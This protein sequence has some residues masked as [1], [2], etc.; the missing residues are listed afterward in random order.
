MEQYPWVHMEIPKYYTSYINLMSAYANV[1][2]PDYA[3]NPDAYYVSVNTLFL[4]I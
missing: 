3:K 2:L 1:Q 4:V